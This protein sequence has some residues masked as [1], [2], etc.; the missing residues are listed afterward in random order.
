MNNDEYLVSD[1]IIT[2]DE[3]I[4]RIQ[5]SLPLR[6]VKEYLDR[7]N[8]SADMKALLYDLARVTVK[9]GEVVVA[10][11]RRVI[12]IAMGL[13]SKFPNMTF[14]VI[15][16]V[17]LVSI[18]GVGAIPILGAFIS[19]LMVLIGLTSGALADIRQGPMKATMDRVATEFA[20]LR[21]VA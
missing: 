9:V 10:V 18:T 6:K 14:G 3:A 5:T 2:A 17:V 15:V 1:Q 12:D 13:I 8:L 19:K 16:A 7:T 20:P 4:Q 21:S 11:G